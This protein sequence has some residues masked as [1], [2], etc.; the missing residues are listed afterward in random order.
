[1]KTLLMTALALLMLTACSSTQN[2]AQN[3]Y[4][5][6]S[7]SLGR[8]YTFQ[9]KV[10]ILVI[11]NVA[12]SDI[13]SGSGI[14]YQISNTETVAANNN[15]W[16][17]GLS[18]QLTRLIISGLREKQTR[19]WPVGTSPISS[20]SPVQTLWVKMAQFNGSYTGDAMLA[21]EWML[22]DDS[23]NI[24]LSETFQ[25][26]EPLKQE[27]YPALVDALSVALDTLTTQLASTL[28]P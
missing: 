11:P 15:R 20:T 24:L 4:L 23:G 16:A 18:E 21:G 8:T 12:V 28:N 19:Y 3:T 9:N 14:V 7:D 10:P 1:M 26:S 6:T 27:G 13:L 2:I 22:F 5:L 17:E 25:I